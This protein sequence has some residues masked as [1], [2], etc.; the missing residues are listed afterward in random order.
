MT[1]V[2]GR[3]AR[4]NSAGR[5]RL[6]GL[7]AGV[8]Y[9]LHL[10]GSGDIA[11]VVAPA[12]GVD[13]TVPSTGALSGRLLLPP[14]AIS[15]RQW[16]L[17]L[18]PEGQ[19]PRLLPL[20]WNEG[21]FRVAGLPAGR[22]RFSA[23]T[24][25]ARIPPREIEIPA[26]RAL[27]LGELRMESGPLVRGVVRDP[28]GVPFAGRFVQL[29]GSRLAGVSTRSESEGRFLLGC[30]PPGRYAVVVGQ[31]LAGEFT[32]RHEFDVGPDGADID[33]VH[34]RGGTVR[35]TARTGAGVPLA[36]SSVRV[37]PVA[38]GDPAVLATVSHLGRWSVDLPEG[39]YRFEIVAADGGVRAEGRAKVPEGGEAVLDLVG[40]R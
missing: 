29:I 31:A 5:F 32:S 7:D 18:E 19:A 23:I 21:R 11:E 34:P 40:E 39:D 2:T 3:A 24:L 30:L 25:E 38:G 14:G 28:A 6:D 10:M 26:D 37:A 27:E 22:A 20:D 4:S 12:T 16:N 8:R 1:D 33:L 35:G 36:G 17:V 15:P 13:F 9:R